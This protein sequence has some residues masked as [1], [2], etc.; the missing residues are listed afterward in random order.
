MIRIYT[1]QI[2]TGLALVF[3]F[4]AF[5][6]AAED[7]K[8]SFRSY[9]DI[10]APDMVA[11]KVLE[12]SV[13]VGKEYAVYD[14]SEQKFI[15]SLLLSNKSPFNVNIISG[16]GSDP[17]ALFDE[18]LSSYSDFKVFEGDIMQRSEIILDFGKEI[19]TDGFK[20][21]L[22]KNSSLPNYVLV[23]DLDGASLALNK[24]GMKSNTVHFPK[25]KS[26]QIAIRFEHGQPL[27]I[28]EIKI[29]GSNSEV[30]DANLR[31]LA[32]SKHQYRIFADREYF[33][34]IPYA[35]DMPNLQDDRDI[36]RLNTKIKL[37]E[38]PLFREPDGDKDGIPDKFDNCVDLA[39]PDQKDMDKNGRG[40]ACDDFD[41]DGVINIK[42]NCPLVPNFSQSDLDR[43][44]KGDVCDKEEDRVFEKYPWLTWLAFALVVLLFAFM[45]AIV[46][47]KEKHELDKKQVDDLD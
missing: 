23:Y 20:L 25:I 3:L 32:R 29:L 38:N 46:M 14:L 27:R 36:L 24:I 12:L 18:N 40:D 37:N 31:F 35:E 13:P 45:T 43:D 5:V 42:D 28:S 39:N 47:R 34:S 33:I 10:V 22:D 1:Q 30:K 41:K 4:Y 19:E 6:F 16:G 17:D 44:G 2:F 8:A 26:R 9:A 7:P 11:P 15:P 21:Y